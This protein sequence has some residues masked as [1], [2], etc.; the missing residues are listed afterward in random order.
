LRVAIFEDTHVKNLFPIAY[1]RPAFELKCGGFN[2]ADKVLHYLQ[3]PAVSYFVR[4]YLVPTFTKK[5]K[6]PIND[7]GALKRED[8]LLINGRWIWCKKEVELEGNEEI[9]TCGDAVVYARVK[10]ETLSKTKAVTLAE[11]LTE[12][13]SLVPKKNVDVLMANYPWDLVLNNGKSIESDFSIIGG[14]GVQGVLH[15]QAYIH[16][17]AGRVFIGEGAV[18]HPFVELDTTGGPVII[19]ENVEV[20]PF[21]RIEGPA[22]IGKDAQIMPGS[23]IREGTTIGPVC[24][25]GGEVEESIIHGHSN[26]YHDGFLGHAYVCKWVNLGALTTNSDLKNDYTSVQ[27]YINGELVDTGSPK[28][29]CFIGDHT[30][31]SIGT[32]LN[33]GT[34][35]GVMCV[36]VSNGNLFPKYVPSFVWH[37]NGKT[38]RGFGINAQFE[39]A[40]VTMSR[41]NETFSQ[42][43]KDLINHIKD[44]TK[45][46]RNKVLKR[47]RWK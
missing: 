23:K 12:L 16:G 11:I 19:R 39:T 32:L 17:D 42:E 21:T 26:K 15:D 45:E 33:T 10:K 41:R 38:H 27:A 4:D 22:F 30:K 1:I 36:L 25:V 7:V 28:V 3:D 20:F 40:R 5:V 37:V 24:R 46:E 34:V 35:V 13:Q 43:D 18:I 2:L 44:I 47:G 8:H 31:T 14:S 6:A 9:A 29:G